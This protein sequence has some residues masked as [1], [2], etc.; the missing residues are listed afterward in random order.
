MVLIAGILPLIPL[1][2]TGHTHVI[3]EDELRNKI[4]LSKRD[5]LKAVFK[6]M[7]KIKHRKDHLTEPKVEKIKALTGQPPGGTRL[8]Y[9][10][11][12][13]DDGKKLYAFISTADSNSHPPS[14]AVFI[15]LVDGRGSVQDVKIM[16]YK[17]PQRA[18]IISPS[19]L[20]QFVGKTAESDFTSI[21]SNQG[22]SLPVRSLAKAVHRIA[23]KVLVLT[24]K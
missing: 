4:Y 8:D 17:G 18:E 10:Y 24:G 23:A 2:E 21:S 5:A 12:I 20:N 16:E 11:G 7:N 6:G 19:F 22:R 15:T 9:Y 3:P 1:I 14:K 13:R